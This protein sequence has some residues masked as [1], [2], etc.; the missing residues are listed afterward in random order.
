[1][2]TRLTPL[3]P[4]PERQSQSDLCE[5]KARLVY[6]ASSRTARA[7]QKSLVSKIQTN[8]NKKQEKPKQQK[9][10]KKLQSRGMVVVYARPREWHY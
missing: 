8:K 9:S 5:F 7:L 4:A 2:S 10:I 6:E 1:V 3:I